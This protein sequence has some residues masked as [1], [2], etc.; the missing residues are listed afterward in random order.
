VTVAVTATPDGVRVPIKAV[1]GASRDRIVGPLG[2]RL[3]VQVAAPPEGGR[4]NARIAELLAEALGVPAR[5]VRIVA[6]L[7][8]PQ[9][10]VEVRGVA[11]NDVQARLRAFGR[12]SR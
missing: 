2:D 9:K 12:A 10:T 6:G 11:V 1:P 3:K 4:A 7:Q 5:D 8:S